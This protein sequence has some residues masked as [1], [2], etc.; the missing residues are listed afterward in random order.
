MTTKENFE[1]LGDVPVLEASREDQLKFDSYA[2]VL[3]GAAVQTKEPITIGVFG[4]WGTGKTSLMR[5]MKK[6]V[7]DD[8]QAAA[9]WFNAWQYEKEEHLIVPLTATIARAL[10]TKKL[11][12]RMKKGAAKLR[13][14]IR[15]IAYGFSIKGKVGI[16]LLSE[17]EVNLSPKGMIEQYQN[18][19]KDAVLAQSLYF[20]AFES[21]E[22]CAKETDMPRIVVFVDDLDRCFPPKAVSLIEGIKLVLNQPGFA[23]VLGVND[24]IIQEFVKNKYAKEYQVDGSHLDDYLDKIVQVSVRV[25]ERSPDKMTTFI[26]GLL[27]SGNVFKEDI[28]KELAEDMVTLIAEAGKRNPR[29]IVR[30]LNRVKV[31]RGIGKID[32]VEHDPIALLLHLAMD[33]PRY[34]DLRNNLDVP[35]G[36]E[37]AT[38]I[39]GRTLADLFSKGTDGI[40]AQLAEVKLDGYAGQ[41]FK[42]MQG[43]LDA[44]KH[45]CRILG[46]EPGL[47]WLTDEEGYRQKLGEAVQSTQREA[48]KQLP[49]ETHDAIVKLETDMVAIAGGTFTMGSDKYDKEKP[50]HEVSVRP[51]HMLAAPVT[52]A[53]YEAVMGNNPSR[54]KGADQPVEQISWQDAKNFCQKLSDLTGAQYRLP[55]EAEWEYACRAGN[56][57]DYCFGDNTAELEEYAWYGKNSNGQTQPVGKK[58]ANRFGLFDVHGNVWEWVEDKWHDTYKGAPTD[59]SAWIEGSDEKRVLRGGSWGSDNPDALRASYRSSFDP[60]FRNSDI[61]YRCVRSSH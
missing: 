41:R 16:P 57:G 43:V 48:L 55:T 17:A 28:I 2:Q 33:E 29:S 32:G 20:D 3:A 7:D 51:F 22:A 30:L 58:K 26:Q 35:V 34:R 54:F 36:E 9:V 38:S 18:L 45:L 10:D 42:E 60:A 46:T 25:P 8:N 19:T 11:A 39:L 52:Q 59:G 12:A 23:F 44:N 15:A 50:P 4:D 14:A 13:D 31:T 56:Q 61:G 5:L 24:Q 53:Q 37:A 27:S 47:K 40:E 21:L 1:L 6:I 49:A